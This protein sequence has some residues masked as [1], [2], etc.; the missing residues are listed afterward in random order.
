MMDQSATR[1]GF[2]P[3]KEDHV[4]SDDIFKD[5]VASGN[6]YNIDRNVSVDKAESRDRHASLDD[7]IQANAGSGNDQNRNETDYDAS[8]PGIFEADPDESL[9]GTALNI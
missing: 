8:M 6:Q 3:Q 4:S 1:P 9:A 7:I 5:K 2:S